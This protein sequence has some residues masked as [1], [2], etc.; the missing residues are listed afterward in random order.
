M[1]KSIVLLVMVMSICVSTSVFAQKSTMY[2]GDKSNSEISG[3]VK[4]YRGLID[5]LKERKANLEK[6]L[7]KML[8]NPGLNEFAIT[9][10]DTMINACQEK[11]M[12]LDDQLIA[13]TERA[14]GKD[15]QNIINLKSRNLPAMTDAIIAVNYYSKKGNNPLNEVGASLSDSALITNDWHREVYVTISGP[16][17]FHT[18]F[19]I[20]ANSKVILPVP[21]PGA[22]SVVFDFGNEKKYT[23]KRFDGMNQDF[24]SE[25]G[26]KYAFISGINRR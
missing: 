14:A 3:S 17:R 23:C 13:F 4:I 18:S 5:D 15:E 11:I 7:K 6:S 2:V 25:N 12:S 26:R 1:K 8:R 16:A 24:D 20:K 10:T 21:G 9:R 22:Y 19:R